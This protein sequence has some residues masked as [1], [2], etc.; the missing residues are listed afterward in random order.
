MVAKEKRNLNTGADRNGVGVVMYIIETKHNGK[1]KKALPVEI[2]DL[3][4]AESMA[5]RLYEETKEDVRVVD[6]RYRKK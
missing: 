4:E 5:C 6:E 1:W 3:D 2:A